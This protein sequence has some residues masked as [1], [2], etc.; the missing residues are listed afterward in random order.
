M[1]SMKLGKAKATRDAYRQLEA[2]RSKA[3]RQAR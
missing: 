3:P 2:L 1:R